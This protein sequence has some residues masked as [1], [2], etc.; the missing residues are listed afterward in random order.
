MSPPLLLSPTHL[1]ENTRETGEPREEN[2]P[3]GREGRVQGTGVIFAERAGS[4]K[5]HRGRVETPG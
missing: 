5:F 2:T 4:G 1:T 3:L